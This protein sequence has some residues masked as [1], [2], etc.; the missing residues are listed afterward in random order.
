[1]SK[2]ESR[3]RAKVGAVLHRDGRISFEGLNGI[4]TRRAI[5]SAEAV[6]ESAAFKRYLSDSRADR[7][8]RT[9]RR[10]DRMTEE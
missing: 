7:E 5:P 8:L 6:R 10:F 1:M 2:R 3:I 4:V 9:A